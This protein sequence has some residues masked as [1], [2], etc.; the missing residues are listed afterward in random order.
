MIPAVWAVVLAW[1]LTSYLV[2]R[3][4]LHPAVVYSG[5]WL[6]QITG[7]LFFS[8]RFVP[9]SLEAMT[10]VILGCLAFTTG[11]HIRFA[12]YA[13]PRPSAAPRSIPVGTRRFEI[14]AV[15]VAL[16]L[17]AQHNVFSTLTAG[18]DFDIGLVYARKLI[19]IDGEDIYGL[20]KY[21]SPLALSGLLA[22]QVL[23]IR[24]HASLKHKLLCVFF[25][26]AS[27]AMAV[28]STGRGPVVFVF[29][30]TGMAYV[31]AGP[32]AG[33]RRRLATL[34]ASI[35]ALMFAVFW[36]MGRA[37]GKAD[38]DAGEA[39]LNLADYLFSSIPA[40]SVFIA[41][42]PVSPFGE[43]HGSNTFRIFHAV[44][45]ALGMSPP[46]PSLVQEFIPVPHLTNLYTIYLHYILDFGWAGVV[47]LPMFL[48][49]VHGWLFRAA[50]ADRR[51]EFLLI[52]LVISYLP[53]LQV[54]FQET[55]FST[56]ATW[57]QLFLI[58]L[59]LTRRQP[60]AISPS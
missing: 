58:C 10:V 19:S 23:W 29:L 48:G 38:D 14:V 56:V 52:L 37:L 46:P 1:T 39:L 42:N 27:L 21:G 8:E 16:S 9:L 60:P 15:V 59:M 24:G 3:S 30:L 43:E 34:L 26:I 18:L 57:I 44:A 5:I 25:L 12:A 32:P 50:A 55:H 20:S 22:L 2:S 31:L 54:G 47:L 28:L 13:A 51:R 17:W 4:V 41:D 35:T 45:A 40:L 7:L 36:I 11:T 53:L 6:F 33:Q 49:A